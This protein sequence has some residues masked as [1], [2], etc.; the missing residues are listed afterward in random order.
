MEKHMEKMEVVG[1][2]PLVKD[3]KELIHP[4]IPV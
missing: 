2:E 4:K 3:I 1:Y